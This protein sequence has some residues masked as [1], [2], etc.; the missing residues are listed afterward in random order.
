MTKAIV[1]DKS[2]LTQRIK[3]TKEKTGT[4]E[5]LN[6]VKVNGYHTVSINEK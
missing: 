3:A 2:S 1:D 5:T 6:T 4:L